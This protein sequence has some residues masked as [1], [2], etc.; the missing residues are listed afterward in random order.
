MLLL[1][2]D[3][4]SRQQCEIA[5]K[6][7]SQPCCAKPDDCNIPL[8]FDQI[9]TLLEENGMTSRRERGQL[10]ETTL[11]AEIDLRRPVLLADIFEN[12][13]D[14]HVRVVFGWSAI[15]RGARLIRVADPDSEHPRSTTFDELR[16]SRWR[17][18]WH[19][20]EVR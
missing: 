9:S 4:P 3:L 19:R 16:R 17:Q 8:N 5:S 13:T 15:S 2:Q 12:G 14:G 7:L 10:P 18:T 20:I 6:R 1:Y 11:W